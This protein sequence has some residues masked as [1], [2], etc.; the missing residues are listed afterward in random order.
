MHTTIISSTIIFFE[1]IPGR[2]IANFRLWTEL[3]DG[4]FNE[5]D[6]TY[7]AMPIRNKRGRLSDEKR[8]AEVLDP[9][10]GIGGVSSTSKLLEKSSSHESPQ[11][12]ASEIQLSDSQDEIGQVPSTCSKALD[13]DD[14]VNTVTTIPKDEIVTDD[15]VSDEKPTKRQITASKDKIVSDNKVS[16]DKPS[17]KRNKTTTCNFIETAENIPRGSLRSG[18]KRLREDDNSEEHVSKRIRAIIAMI[19]WFEEKPTGMNTRTC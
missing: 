6:G 1:D 5:I 19:N 18:T 17:K 12:S 2:S 11:D 13:H 16:D 10:A 3:S 9:S 14:I 8:V 7:N 15:K 4:N